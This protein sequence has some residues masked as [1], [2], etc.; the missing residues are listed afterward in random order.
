[1]NAS[2]RKIPSDRVTGSNSKYVPD[3]EQFSK[4]LSVDFPQTVYQ[5]L[6]TPFLSVVINFRGTKVV[7]NSE[8]REAEHTRQHLLVQFGDR[9]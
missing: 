6:L 2:V 3:F 9:V 8:K 4:L 7:K 1:M 5:C